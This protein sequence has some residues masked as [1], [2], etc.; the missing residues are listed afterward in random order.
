[1]R[2]CC[3][4]A[5]MIGMVTLLGCDSGPK[6]GRGLS[7]PEG[8]VYKG[9]AAFVKLKCHSCHT[10]DGVELPAVNDAA[11]VTVAI[12]G[13]VRKVRSYGELVTSI[14]NPSHELVTRYPESE[15][16]T[17]GKSRMTNFNA[18]MSVDQLIDL[19]AFLQSRYEKLEPNYDSYYYPYN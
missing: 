18:A 16:T 10:V 9:K 19:V 7:L 3:A 5:L 8:D 6:S 13:K 4:W 12:G 17:D 2:L 11:E 15:I 1:M 14:I